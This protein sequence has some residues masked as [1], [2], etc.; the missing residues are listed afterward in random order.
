MLTHII[1]GKMSKTLSSKG[2]SIFVHQ[3]KIFHQQ[4]V[5]EDLFALNTKT[6]KKGLIDLPSIA[7]GDNADSIS[8]ARYLLDRLNCL[9][10]R[11]AL[12]PQAA[13][14]RFEKVCKAFLTATFL[15]FKHLRPGIWTIDA[16]NSRTQLEIA[17]FEQYSHLKNVAEACKKDGQLAASL[18]QDYLIAPDIV[19]LRTPEPDEAINLPG[20]TMVDEVRAR[21]TGMRAANNSLP[22]LHA[23]ISCKLTIRSDRVQNSRSEALNL[24]RN[25]EGRVPHIT[26]ITAE[27]LPSRLSAIALGT[28][29]IDCVYHVALDEL[30]EAV[31]KIGADSQESLRI[32]MEG[33][34]LR[35]IADL[36]LD[37]AV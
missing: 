36:P 7:D 11:P 33:K 21:R 23:S 9:N 14:S 34:R 16:L 28:G 2:A 18:G 27:P 1:A 22:L 25:R 15:E 19:V 12:T 35:D 32:M 26:V 37:L 4:L 31:K 10:V 29:D 8:I 5:S 24:I 20:R 13:G 6:K 30:H 3:R 17:R